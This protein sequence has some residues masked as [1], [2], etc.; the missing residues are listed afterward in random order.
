MVRERSN[1]VL[2]RPMFL[3]RVVDVVLIFGAL[4]Y[5][6]SG[7]FVTAFLIVAGSFCWWAGRL[8]RKQRRAQ[9]RAAELNSRVHGSSSGRRGGQ[10]PRAGVATG[11]AAGMVAHSPVDA[12]D[13]M[14]S[15][16]PKFNID[17]TPMIGVGSID[18]NGNA[19]GITSSAYTPGE[20]FAFA[21]S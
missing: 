19:F 1:A 14:T 6:A 9:S 12:L 11:V 3:A 15:A 17:G 16:S 10:A 7:R 4:V 8:A 5:L 21:T 18:V 20:D 13:E 2:S